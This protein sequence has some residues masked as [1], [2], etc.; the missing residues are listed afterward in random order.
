[1]A[2]ATP[3]I[4]VFDPFAVADFGNDGYAWLEELCHDAPIGTRAIQRIFCSCSQTT[5]KWA[6][7]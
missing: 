6:K 2:E 3:N 1:V 4:L 5:T 7:I